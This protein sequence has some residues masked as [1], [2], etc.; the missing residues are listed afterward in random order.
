M[1]EPCVEVHAVAAEPALGQHGGNFGGVLG[2]AQAVR[3]TI[4]RASRGG[5]ASR[6][7]A[8]ALRRDPAIAVERAE[9]T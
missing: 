7:Q 6:A 2:R 5:S 4:M 8:L 1:I 9:F 3:V